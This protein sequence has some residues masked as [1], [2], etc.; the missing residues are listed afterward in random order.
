LIVGVHATSGNFGHNILGM[1]QIRLWNVVFTW[2]L[3]AACGR[4]ELRNKNDKFIA[5]DLD[6][7]NLYIEPKKHQKYRNATDDKGLRVGVEMLFEQLSIA[8]FL[9][10]DT[11]DMTKFCLSL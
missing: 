3:M 10:D 2:Q 7:N 5:A 6:T 1:T 8:V 11:F 4:V 9:N